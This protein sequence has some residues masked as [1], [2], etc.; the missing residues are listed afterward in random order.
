MILDN[1]QQTYDKA[2]RGGPMVK[3]WS[4][5]QTIN[6]PSIPSPKCRS[7]YDTISDLLESATELFGDKLQTNI[8]SQI[9][10]ISY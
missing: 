10:P 4:C 9:F 5:E 6:H 7:K 8:N 1:T 3:C 2:S